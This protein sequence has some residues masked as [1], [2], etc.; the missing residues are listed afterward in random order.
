LNSAQS[1]FGQNNRNNNNEQD[2]DE[3]IGMGSIGASVS[4]VS[5]KAEF[6]TLMEENDNNLYK[7]LLAGHNIN[8]SLLYGELGDWGQQSFKLSL[9]LDGAASLKKVEDTLGEL[10]H[11]I[12]TESKA[13]KKVYMKI[14]AILHFPPDD[15]NMHE[16]GNMTTGGA[17]QLPTNPT[18]RTLYY[19]AISVLMAQFGVSYPVALVTAINT[20]V[21]TDV[22][23]FTLPHNAASTGN[24]DYI[25]AK[26]ESAKAATLIDNLAREYGFTHTIVLGEYPW[27]FYN[28][29]LKDLDSFEN[30]TLLLLQ[31]FALVHPSAM[32]SPE[33]NTIRQ[34]FELVFVLC[35]M[36]SDISGPEVEPVRD[37]TLDDDITTLNYAQFGLDTY[38]KLGRGKR[39]GQF[40]YYAWFGS[41]TSRRLIFLAR[42]RE[43]MESLIT[44]ELE[45]ITIPPGTWNGTE[46]NFPTQPTLVNGTWGIGLPVSEETYQTTNQ[47]YK[48]LTIGAVHWSDLIRD[49]PP[50]GSQ[51]DSGASGHVTYQNIML[52]NIT[53]GVQNSEALQA[54]KTYVTEQAN[55]HLNPTHVGWTALTDE[56]MNQ[57]GLA[58]DFGLS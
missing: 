54:W 50:R 19:L 11:F 8:I 27:E 26:K 42:N 45:S 3:E 31:K 58:V 39:T 53:L 15:Q 5:T 32:L 20:I 6:D 57:E 24:A 51:R 44:N 2:S 43:D 14:L 35:A 13:R 40:F 33:K 56:F 23:P 16:D 1:R 4:E 25:K 9:G 7:V 18:L 17:N 30:I 29:Y 52:G 10:A 47:Q 38:I 55:Q 12:H 48:Y 34:V 37:I 49:V 46:P 36:F 21:P 28:T 22:I 41:G